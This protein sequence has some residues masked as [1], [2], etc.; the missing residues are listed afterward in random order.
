MLS[1][2]LGSARKLGILFTATEAKMTN[3]LCHL[4]T[5]VLYIHVY[6]ENNEGYISHASKQCETCLPT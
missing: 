3:E 6:D 1:P 5:C 4:K 2:V